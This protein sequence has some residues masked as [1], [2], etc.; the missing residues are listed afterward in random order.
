MKVALIAASRIPSTTANSIQVMK[1]GQAFAQLGHETRL[2]V[3]AYSALADGIPAGGD[4]ASLAEFYG[5]QNTFA[6]E[7]LVSNPALKRYDFS[8]LAVQKAK[9]WGA[10]AVYLWPLQSA[11]AAQVLGLPYWLE[12]HEPPTGKLG[13]LLFRL[14]LHPG[15]KCFLPIT[16]VLAGMLEARYPAFT[17]QRL[18]IQ[19]APD[20]VDLERYIDLPS[21]SAARQALHFPEQLTVGYTGHLYAGRGMALLVGLAR[22]FPQVHFLW[23]GGRPEDVQSWQEHLS[24]QGLQN[25]TLTGFI[26][27]QRLAL[28]QAAADILLMPYDRAVSGSSGGNTADFCSPMKMFEYMACGRAIISS[29]LP[30][31]GEVLNTANARLCPPEDEDA[32]A[33][34]LGTLL[35]DP[36]LRI[37]LI[38]LLPNADLIYPTRSGSPPSEIHLR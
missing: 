15:R 21:P 7:W 10:D 18:T 1:V 34:A 25:V 31:I 27:N 5:L 24:G 37:R 29:D 16:R 6:V 22:R 11:L 12:L 32:W 19:I 28:Y 23:V 20:G 8:W 3:P 35:V 9:T 26:P 38:E 13:P 33:D 2:F 30:A 17:P 14:L 4:Q 36:A